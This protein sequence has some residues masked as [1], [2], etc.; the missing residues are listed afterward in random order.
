VD[1]DPVAHGRGGDLGRTV[2]HS[3]YG[4]IGDVRIVNRPLQPRELMLGDKRR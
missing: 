1:R 4:W 3:F 2:E